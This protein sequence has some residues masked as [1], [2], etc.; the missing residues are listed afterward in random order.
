MGSALVP[1]SAKYT[2]SLDSD[3]GEGPVTYPF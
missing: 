2:L 1:C 3:L